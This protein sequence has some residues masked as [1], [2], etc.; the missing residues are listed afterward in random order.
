MNYRDIYPAFLGGG[1]SMT[2]EGLAVYMPRYIQLV[3]EMAG[4]A[5]SALFEPFASV[6]PSDRLPLAQEAKDLFG[7][8]MRAA[9]MDISLIYPNN[10]YQKTA[11]K[12]LLALLCVEHGSGQT[13]LDPMHSL[14]LEGG[15]VPQLVDAIKKSLSQLYTEVAGVMLN[16]KK[17]FNLE[18]DR[19]AIAQEAFQ[20]RTTTG[21]A[22][23]TGCLVHLCTSPQGAK[24]VY[25]SGVLD[26]LVSIFK[27]SL[28][29]HSVNLPLSHPRILPLAS[30]YKLRYEKENARTD[31]LSSSAVRERSKDPAIMQALGISDNC[32]IACLRMMWAMGKTDTPITLDPVLIAY[33]RNTIV[34]IKD[35]GNEAL[36]ADQLRAAHSLYT[37][38]LDFALGTQEHGHQCVVLA[39]RAECLLRMKRYQDALWDVAADA[40][41][42]LN[43]EISPS[44]ATPSST[45]SSSSSS[46]SSNKNRNKKN[47]KNKNKHSSN[48]I[49]EAPAT[50]IS[51][52]LGWTGIDRA[53]MRVKLE[54]RKQRALEGMGMAPAPAP[55]ATPV[56]LSS[57]SSSSQPTESSSS[58]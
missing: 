6:P 21:V 20:H 24:Q 22:S 18:I 23:L 57:S 46:S 7:H 35:T 17:K 45:S 54:S 8:L 27:D 26:L 44:T 32:V 40:L 10:D 36:Q 28:D 14:F 47:R 15:Y 16:A 43:E 2:E 37:F 31:F 5:L 56:P 3:R 58:S 12:A 39:N 55:S 4:F 19:D 49:K 50:V 38:S 25:E 52:V 29:I 33:A 11:A 9:T 41:A 51:S 34:K 13:V 30:G 53:G 48:K 1:N 42:L